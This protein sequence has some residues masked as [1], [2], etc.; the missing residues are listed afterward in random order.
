[1]WTNAP[2]PCGVWPEKRPFASD[3]VFGPALNF[4]LFSCTQNWM[5][6]PSIGLPEFASS[7]KP[8]TFSSPHC[9][10]IT[11]ARSLTQKSVNETMLFASPNALSWLAIR[12]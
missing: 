2:R 10:R 8:S 12:K 5:S 9:Q 1:M 3:F 6:A 11:S 4:P 7:A